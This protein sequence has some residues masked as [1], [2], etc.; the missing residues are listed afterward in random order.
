MF[1]YV[2]LIKYTLNQLTIRTITL[3]TYFVQ[4]LVIMFLY[5]R[6]HLQCFAIFVDTKTDMHGTNMSES[7]TEIKGLYFNGRYKHTLSI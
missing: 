4:Q 5:E 7:P 6:N 2:F 3:F 1:P